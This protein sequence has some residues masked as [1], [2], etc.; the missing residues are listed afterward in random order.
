MNSERSA[1]AS[2]MP[3]GAVAL[4]LTDVDGTIG[5]WERYGEAMG[6]A[7]RRHD[8][9]VRDA[10]ESGGG[11]VVSALGDAFCAAFA[12]VP[13]AIAAAVAM[14]R[15]FAANDWSAVG[16]FGVRAAVHV[17]AL[18]RHG[19]GDAGPAAARAARLVAI[20]HGGQILVSRAAAALAAGGLDADVTFVDCGPQRLKDL[21]PPEHVVRVAA[22][23]LAS[24]FPPLRSLCA[25]PNNL[26]EVRSTFV[27]RK[28]EIAAARA[29]LH[30]SRLVTLAGTGGIGKTRTA[31]H[32]AAETAA[33]YPDGIWLVELAPLGDGSTIASALASVLAVHAPSDADLL[34][35]VAHALR[36]KRALVIFDGCERVLLEAAVTLEAVL[37]VATH[38]RA[39]A[40]SRYALGAA[41]ERVLRM[42]S[43]DV[44]PPGREPSAATALAHSA[45][46]LFVDRA[47]AAVP[48]FTLTD[49]NAATIAAICRRL[50][51]IPYAIELAAPRLRGLTPS[52]LATR[53]GERFRVTSG[54]ERAV[55]SMQ[56]TVRTMIDWSYALLT[57]DERAVFRRLA[58]LHDGWTLDAASAVCGDDRL[59]GWE[60]AAL[61]ESL[62]EKSLVTELPPGTVRRFGMLE[63]ARAFALEKLDEYGELAGLARA[64]ALFFA[65]VA[66]S[67]ADARAT[68]SDGEW[69]ALAASELANV[70]GALQWTLR[71][72]NDPALGVEIVFG[73]LPL[74]RFALRAEGE[75]WVRAAAECLDRDAHPRSAARVLCATA[76]CAT[77]PHERLAASGAALAAARGLVD[78]DVLRVALSTHG[79]HLLD[80]GDDAAAAALFAEALALH[81][82]SGDRRSA[83]AAL[84]ALAGIA[85][86]GGERDAAGELYGEA[87]ALARDARAERAEADALAGLGAL[88]ADDGRIDAAVEATARARDLF[89]AL[90]DVRGTASAHCDL[91]A[92]AIARDAFADARLHARS[93]L[94][95]LRDQPDPLLLALAIERVAVTLGL[96][97]DAWRAARLAGFCDASYRRL[98]PAPER[99]RRHGDERLRALLDARFG[100]ADLAELLAFGA[101]LGADEALAEALA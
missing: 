77:G 79:G 57:S 50:D 27:G 60:V 3:A 25:S 86:R 10:I 85:R 56:Q 24:A 58:I 6:E 43:L 9:L 15:A 98:A 38:V 48:A 88:A 53:L 84:N 68:L 78:R 19:A 36:H 39:L 17:G 65:Q 41:R 44:P 30:E 72:A 42:P 37:K 31:L 87:L 94:A 12:T 80:A 100:E 82:A 2:G 64:H 4:L 51:G 29:L 71:E 70:R 18:A 49:S 21:G 91:A 8:A 20:A 52:Q 32:V 54:G 69:V 55:P 28:A 95:I 93:A 61:A 97:G 16:G 40:T 11:T 89:L 34:A 35:H 33:D 67:I 92:Y 74:W 96:E 75:A 99:P 101:A 13:H 90:R 22:P 45:V 14:Q 7:L 5:R 1:L 47:R 26:P 76:A 83:A 73:L 63:S 46:A 23:G 59:G 81:R 66:R 62:V